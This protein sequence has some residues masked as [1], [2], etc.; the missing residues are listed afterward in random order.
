MRGQSAASERVRSEC[1]S[2]AS[3][4]MNFLQLAGGNKHF[5]SFRRMRLLDFKSCLVQLLV[6]GSD[7]DF[8]QCRLAALVRQPFPL[9][10]HER[11]AFSIQPDDLFL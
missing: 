7:H 5:V 1:R 10:S 9:S 4:S 3:L 6:D 8:T 2:S 11:F